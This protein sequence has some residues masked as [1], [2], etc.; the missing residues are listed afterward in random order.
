MDDYE[1]WLEYEATLNTN[2]WK[3]EAFESIKALIEEETNFIA[4]SVQI[5]EGE[6]C[7]KCKGQRT[8][9]YQKQ[10]RRADEGF[11]SFTICFDCN[12]QLVE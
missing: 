12:H 5:E 8:Y 7:V 3:H 11:T 10:V 9:T 4:H 6:P 1:N 2:D